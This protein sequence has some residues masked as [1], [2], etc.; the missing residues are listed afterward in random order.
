MKVFLDD[1]RIAP[2]GW[3]QT[4]TVEETI[5]KLSTGRVKELSLDNDLG[6]LKE[7]YQVLDWLEEQAFFGKTFLIPG[8]ISVHSS[9]A[10]ARVRMLK[11]IEKLKD[12]KND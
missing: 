7:G 6:H 8:K 11:V 5:E 9:N 3:I 2:A 10:S 1:M 4:Y 12:Y